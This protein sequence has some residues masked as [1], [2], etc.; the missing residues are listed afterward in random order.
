MSTTGELKKEGS[1]YIGYIAD[2]AFDADINLIPNENKKDDK[3]PD[4]LINGKSPRG[5]DIEI[6]AAWW[7]ESKAGNR[8]LGLSVNIL[9]NTHRVNGFLQDDDPDT[10]DIRAWANVS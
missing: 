1:R 3:H 4:Y 2:L 5:R 10:V 7:R 8:Y 6:G 9:G